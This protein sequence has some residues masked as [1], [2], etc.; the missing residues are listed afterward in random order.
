M[1]WLNTLSQTTTKMTTL[2]EKIEGTCDALVGALE[3][4]TETT[5][6]YGGGIVHEF[7]SEF[8]DVVIKTLI[9]LRLYTTRL[10][11]EILNGLIASPEDLKLMV[12]GMQ[13][14]SDRLQT[15]LR[16][17][18][19]LRNNF[20]YGINEIETTIQEILSDLPIK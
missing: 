14:L 8:V 1:N 3:L 10:H 13:E 16:E 2:L 17:N 15:L 7:E 4:T 9:Q 11:K 6:Q 5:S 18:G 19:A 12:G 20:A